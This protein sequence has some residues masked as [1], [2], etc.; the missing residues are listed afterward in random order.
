MKNTGLVQL[1]Q[2]DFGAFMDHAAESASEVSRSS[3][4][5]LLFTILNSNESISG[6]VA[7][8]ISLSQHL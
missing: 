7:V 5:K 2:K 6:A 1:A 3:N 8:E 4:F